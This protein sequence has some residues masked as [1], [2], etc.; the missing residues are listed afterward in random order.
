MISDRISTLGT[1]GKAVTVSQSVAATAVA[2][3]ATAALEV[4]DELTE[5]F[6]YPRGLTTSAGLLV[7][8][9]RELLPEMVVPEETF[10]FGHP[11]LF[12]LIALR[13]KVTKLQALPQQD[14]NVSGSQTFAETAAGKRLRDIEMIVRHVYSKLQDDKLVAARV[15]AYSAII[16][17][18]EEQLK[19]IISL[20]EEMHTLLQQKQSDDTSSA[21]ALA[22]FCA[23]A[24]DLYTSSL[25]QSPAYL[26]Y[27]E[28]KPTLTGDSAG[29]AAFLAQRRQVLHITSRRIF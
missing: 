14:F 10:R 9:G 5:Q 23:S 17:R 22:Q 25:Q 12:E 8:D 7:R 3:A 6:M 19:E 27:T 28:L 20:L 4:A 13:I 24:S 16:A 26:E 1:S 2:A 21:T 18:A 15:R 29:L 11:I